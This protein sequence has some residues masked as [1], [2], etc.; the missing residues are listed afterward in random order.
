MKGPVNTQPCETDPSYCRFGC[1]TT[2]KQLDAFEDQIDGVLKSSDI[3]YVHRMRVGSR[4][5]RAALPIFK[6]CFPQKDYKKWRHEIKEVTRLLSNA[7]DLD[8]QIAFIERYKKNL[9]PATRKTGLDL[10]LRELEEQRKIVQSFVVNGLE[11]LIASCVLKD[12]RSFCL[13]TTKEQANA[14]FDRDMVLEK[15]HWHISLRLDD[16]LAMEKYVYLENETLKLHQMRICAKKLRYTM[17]HF[18]PLYPNKL[19]GE[20]ERIKAFQDV[21]DEMHECDVWVDYIPKFIEETKNKTQP[22][23]NNKADFAKVEPELSD[24]LTYIIQKRKEHYSQFVQLWNETKKE[25]FFVQLRNTT[26]VGLIT[27]EQK[28]SQALTNPDVKIAVIS[29]V[30]ANLQALERVIQDAEERRIDV[31]LNAGD[32]IG[33]GPFPNEVME[34][35]CEKNVLSVVGNY[36]LEVIEG[37]TKEKGEK[38]LAL[39]FARKE[40]SKACKDYLRLLPRELRFEVAGKKLLVTHGSPESIDEHIYSDTSVERLETFSN[41]AKADVIIVGHSHEQLLRE[42][43]GTS[44][45]NPGSVG[46]PGDG[47]PQAAYSILEFNPFKVETI[48]LDYDVAAAADALRKKSLP[49]S[50]SQ[51]LLQGVSLGTIIEQDT[52]REKNAIKNR[53]YII[54]ACQ[55]FASGHWN[56]SEHYS[57][58]TKLSLEFFDGLINVHKL[59][60]RERCWLEYAAILHDVGLSKNRGGHHRESAKLILNDTQLP[61]SSRE[62]R[63]V[64]SIARY[65]RKGLPKQKHYNLRSL[66]RNTVN[67]IKILASLL[68]VAD[69]LDYE[70]QSNVKTLSFKVNTK[71]ITVEC[72]GETESILEE[73]AFNKKKDLFERVLA[74][75]LVLS[76]KTKRK[77]PNV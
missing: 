38:N 48:R 3:E 64:A 14:T 9:K 65:H 27:R 33:F 56:D 62:R 28:I 49:E 34:L 7:R 4:R 54:K 57:Q 42:V 30:H 70:H 71:K 76:W 73:Q 50:F 13:Q 1:E 11:K 10:L 52:T 6:V 24:F 58:V 63:I 43:N 17:E 41:S 59:G 2:L 68:R 66:D 72:L 36:D 12:L 15:A 55:K 75:K 74:K 20:I 32:S 21:L 47:N 26:N 29:D 67:T 51:M 53:K 69:S 16:F 77:T 22:E 35:L 5:I 25:A 61:F 23:K 45:V 19:T 8:V 46:R 44:F 40:L 60:E 31:F 39:K 18:A 37:K